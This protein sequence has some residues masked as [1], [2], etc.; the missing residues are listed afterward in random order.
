MS[1]KQHINASR[2]ITGIFEAINLIGL[3][4]FALAFVVCLGQTQ[5]MAAS[6]A[7]ILAGV[8]YFFNKL[9]YIGLQLLTDI[10]EL[11]DKQQRQDAIEVVEQG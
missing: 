6:L 4:V 2:T 9:A 5:L 1:V 7:A 10:T 8:W 3:L 11:L